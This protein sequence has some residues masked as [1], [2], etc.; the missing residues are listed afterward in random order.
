[1]SVED[2]PIDYKVQPIEK[3]FSLVVN[4]GLVRIGDRFANVFV[5]I[6]MDRDGELHIT[7]VEGPLANGN[8]RG[9]CGQIG[10]S[11]TPEFVR[12]NFKI[13]FPRWTEDQFLKFL[14]IWDRWH[15]N[16]MRA[17]TPTQMEWI[18]S[19]RE[20]GDDY[21]KTKRKLSEAELNPDPDTGYSYGS[22]WLKEDVPD[23]V[24]AFLEGLPETN[25]S[26]AWV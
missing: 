14:E 15:L 20:P 2:I 19:N 21:V 6:R 22:A 5:S 4:P 25:K 16:H 18:R 17:G 23:S 8:A 1:L 11:Y 9:S 3:T 12:A 7:G 10:V 13:N 26:Y 24:L